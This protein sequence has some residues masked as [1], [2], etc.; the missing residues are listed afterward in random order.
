[1][2]RYFVGS[3]WIHYLP[4]SFLPFTLTYTHIFS[5]EDI[6]VTFVCIVYLDYDA[7]ICTN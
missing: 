6:D 7:C 4:R 3:F 2:V 5:T 1:M